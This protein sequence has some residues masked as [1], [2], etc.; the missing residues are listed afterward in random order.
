LL[1][2]IKDFEDINYIV[3][4]DNSSTDGSYD[5]LKQHESDKIIIL[6]AQENKGY[7]AGNN[8]GI[9]YAKKQLLCDIAIVANPDVAFSDGCVH[10]IKEI[11]AADEKIAVVSAIQVKPDGSI[12]R[13]TAWN[14][15]TK[16]QYI[17]SSLYLLGKVIAPKQTDYTREEKV[18]Y[19]ECVSGAFL[20]IRIDSFFLVDGYDERMFLYCEET[21]LGI[22]MKKAGYK[23]VL[24]TNEFYKH[25]HSVSTKRSIPSAVKR[26]K[27]LLNSRLF[28][29]RQYM[30]ATKGEL[31]C[32][33][34]CYKIA[35]FEEAMKVIIRKIAS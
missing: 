10:N 28:V 6:R 21:T 25:F 8:L 3:V 34:V 27:L 29:L 4:V 7:G 11:F 31:V 30:H 23:T 22:K 17:F 14:I 5:N 16:G 32:A 19:V 1:K 24:L 2:K 12:I 9:K 13:E 33:R 26:R 20:A 35:L 15:P 18:K